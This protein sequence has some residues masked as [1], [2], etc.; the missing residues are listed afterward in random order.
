MYVPRPI[1]VVAIDTDRTVAAIAKEV[2]ALTKMNWNNT[3]FDNSMPITVLAAKKVGR[4]LKYIGPNDRV[5][6]LYSYYM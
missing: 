3:Q 2:L 4:I 1:D 5:N 6:S